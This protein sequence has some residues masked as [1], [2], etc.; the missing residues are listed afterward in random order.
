MSELNLM[1]EVYKSCGNYIVTLKIDP[2]NDNNL[3][4][5]VYDKRY[6]KYRCRKAFV[7][8][9]EN[10]DIENQFLPSIESDLGLPPIIY[11]VGQWVETDYDEDITKVCSSGIHFYT[12]REAAWYHNKMAYLTSDYSGCIR[13]WYDD[14]RL[15]KIS[16]YQ[17]GYLQKETYFFKNELI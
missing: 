12:T 16:E 1:E 15:L 3:N 9:I 11:K 14:G 5:P 17:V 2:S 6:A 10:K 8:K 13:H 4:R 7:V